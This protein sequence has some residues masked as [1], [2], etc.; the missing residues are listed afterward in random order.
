MFN[1]HCNRLKNCSIDNGTRKGQANE[2]TEDVKARFRDEANVT[3]TIVR[4][5]AKP[6]NFILVRIKELSLAISPE[7]QALARVMRGPA[8][9]DSLPI[10]FLAV[11]TVPQKNILGDFDCVP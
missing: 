8:T 10:L 3:R 2:T 11:F 6:E 4:S 7:P 1:R 9:R 5:N